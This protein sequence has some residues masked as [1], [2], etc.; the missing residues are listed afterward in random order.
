MLYHAR[1]QIQLPLAPREQVGFDTG[2]PAPNGGVQAQ[3]G[4]CCLLHG[5]L[6]VHLQDAARASPRRPLM[7]SLVRAQPAADP[8]APVAAM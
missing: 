7:P 2:R 8:T 4:P 6:V 3:H 1:I 5:G